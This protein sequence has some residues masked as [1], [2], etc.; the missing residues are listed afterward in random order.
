MLA[1]E[2]IRGIPLSE[3]QGVL[4][5][6]GDSTTG[7]PCKSILTLSSPVPTSDEHSSRPLEGSTKWVMRM[8][9]D[10]SH[11]QIFRCGL[12]P[13]RP[14]PGKHIHMSAPAPPA[15]ASARPDRPCLYV[16]LTPEF[17]RQYSEL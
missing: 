5:L 8:M 16:K 12:G 13:L 10:L 15:S 11:A 9:I 7:L 2:W 17:R 4:K 3:R 6:M 1:A 14:A